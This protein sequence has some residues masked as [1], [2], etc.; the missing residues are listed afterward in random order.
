MFEK[1]VQISNHGTA[2]GIWPRFFLQM[3]EIAKLGVGKEE[4]EKRTGIYMDNVMPQIEKF[5][6][7][8]QKFIGLTQDY[9]EGIQ[10]GKIVGKNAARTIAANRYVAF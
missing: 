2:S 7:L 6:D 10:S 1:V 8:Y 5:Y 3:D 4:F 9:R